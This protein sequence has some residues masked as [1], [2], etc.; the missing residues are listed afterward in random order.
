MDKELERKKVKETN[1]GE[2]LL[3]EVAIFGEFAGVSV[4]EVRDVGFRGD[5]LWTLFYCFS[6]STA[7]C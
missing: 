6:F 2:E 5:I 7:N 4:Y 1:V 3:Q